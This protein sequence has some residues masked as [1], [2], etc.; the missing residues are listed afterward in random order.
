MKFRKRLAGSAEYKYDVCLS[1]AADYR[2]YVERVADELR[3]AGVRVFYDRYEQVE[4]WGKDLYAHLSD[5]YS[6]AA[7][8]D[9][10]TVPGLRKSIGYVDLT[11]LKPAELARMIAD[12]LGGQQRSFYLPPMPDLLLRS[13]VE[14]YGP[15]DPMLV[16]ETAEHLLES[17]RSTTA[18][19]REAIIRLFQQGKLLRHACRPPKPRFLRPLI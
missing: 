5:V 3:K 6:T 8:F 9:N 13:Y 2:H 10:T 16:Y 18:D 19:E 17:L 12:K 15:V 14:E 1:F 11:K 7:R 4:L